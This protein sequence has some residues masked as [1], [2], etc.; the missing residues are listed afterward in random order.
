MDLSFVLFHSRVLRI[1]YP[2]AVGCSVALSVE[3]V[4]AVGIEEQI[5][6]DLVALQLVEEAGQTEVQSVT[7]LGWAPHFHC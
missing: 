5:G 4:D 6:F 2:D 1:Y 3:I 7:G